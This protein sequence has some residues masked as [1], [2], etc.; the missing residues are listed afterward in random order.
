MFINASSQKSIVVHTWNY[1]SF[2]WPNSMDIT[3]G[4]YSPET[5]ET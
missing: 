1:E 4:G 3:H 5:P 2:I